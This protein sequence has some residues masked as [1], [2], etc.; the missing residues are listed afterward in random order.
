MLFANY[1]LFSVGD[2]HILLF[3]ENTDSNPSIVPG[4]ESEKNSSY[5]QEDD[6]SSSI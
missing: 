6:Q 1:F 4:R 2:S 5:F 3:H